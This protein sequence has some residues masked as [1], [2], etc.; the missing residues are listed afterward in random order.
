MIPVRVDNGA[1]REGV[2]RM[3]INKVV[4]SG[5]PPIN[6]TLEDLPTGRAFLLPDA[7]GVHA[8]YMKT[9]EGC[10]QHHHRVVS[11]VSGLILSLRGR[12]P[13]IPVE[14][15]STVTIYQ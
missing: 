2:N 9:D 4:V 6:P 12:Q 10:G 11:L 15:G 13:V 1:E 3:A 7:E 5:V 14:G 8:V